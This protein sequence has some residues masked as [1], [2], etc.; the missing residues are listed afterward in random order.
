MQHLNDHKRKLYHRSCYRGI[1]E[2]DII[3]KKFAETFLEELE[4]DDLVDYERILELPDDQLFI[5]ATGRDSVPEDTRSPLLDKL[6]SL[7]YM[8]QTIAK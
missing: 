5:W 2:M 7:S 1:K 3:F 4:G 8:N 6:L